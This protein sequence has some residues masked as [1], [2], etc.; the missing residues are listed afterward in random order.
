MDICQE[1][2][3]VGLPDGLCGTAIHVLPPRKFPGPP[4]HVAGTCSDGLVS[5]HHLHL[6]RCWEDCICSLGTQDL[7]ETSPSYPPLAMGKS[8]GVHDSKS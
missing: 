3:H 4:E 7:L 5:F 6:C 2:D 8:V 1:I